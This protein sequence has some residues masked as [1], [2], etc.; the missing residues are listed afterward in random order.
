M[1]Q[2]TINLI[3]EVRG[4]SSAQRDINKLGNSMGT[5]SKKA[6]TMGDEVRNASFGMTHMIARSLTLVT[7]LGAAFTAFDLVKRGIRG[8]FLASEQYRLGVAELTAITL[9]FIKT[10]PGEGL[11]SQYRRANEY[12]SDLFITLEKVAATTLLTGDEANLL[13]S[14]LLRNGIAI[15]AQND[16]QVKGLQALANAIAIV[17]GNSGDMS[18]QIVSET[19]ALLKGISR[20]QDRLVKL[21]EAVDP[22][23]EDHLR[24]WKE[25]GTVLENMVGLLSGFNSVS[26]DISSTWQAVST[27][28]ETTFNLIT[29]TSLSSFYDDVLNLLNELDR[30]IKSHRVEIETK[31]A[32]AYVRLKRSVL[33][34]LDAFIPIFNITREWGKEIFLIGTSYIAGNL[35]KSIAV[36]LVNALRALK[37]AQA[38]TIIGL[39][40]TGVSYFTFDII[41]RK[42][43]F[44]QRVEELRQPF[45]ELL[46]ENVSQEMIEGFIKTYSKELDQLGVIT[47]EKLSAAFREGLI[48]FE[49]VSGT[50]ASGV[51]AGT[52]ALGAGLG[53]GGPET[54]LRKIGEILTFNKE[55]LDEFLNDLYNP[56]IARGAEAGIEFVPGIDEQT[57]SKF[58]S[59]VQSIENSTGTKLDRLEARM[60]NKA[61]KLYEAFL[62]L[63]ASVRKKREDELN[64]LLEQMQD[65]MV[66]GQDKIINTAKTKTQKLIRE[67]L[68]ID[69]GGA[70]GEVLSIQNALEK[71]QEAWQTHLAQLEVDVG[72]HSDIYQR[73]ASTINQLNQIQEEDAEK[74]KQRALEDEDRARRKAELQEAFGGF[75]ALGQEAGQFG[76]ALQAIGANLS[77]VS[78]YDEEITKLQD[79]ID[80]RRA[81]YEAD[82]ITYKEF[83]ERK[84][85]DEDR[86]EKFRTKKR[87]QTAKSTFG[88]L[89]SIAEAYY[90]ASDKQSKTAFRV[91][92]A[93][94]IGETIMNT[95]SAA[96][97]AYNALA[98]IPIVGPAL[99]AAAAAAAIAF[100]IAQVR[101][102][103]SQK[104]GGTGTPTAGGAPSTSTPG[105]PATPSPPEV[106]PEIVRPLSLTVEVHGNIVDHDEFIRELSEYIDEARGDKAVVI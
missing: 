81:L 84:Q 85:A 67:G 62:A 97:G 55:K 35:V 9:S 47:S 17:A 45:R 53:A 34:I 69:V 73:F 91:M 10:Q 38:G 103:A 19:E 7:V 105:V 59:L 26:G 50:G 25:Q 51:A 104:P 92:Q 82:E 106:E 87:I 88:V 3:I 86:I 79:H 11:A 44:E 58:D 46:D 74:R 30:Y 100:G 99:G 54:Q 15:N 95:Y 6:K 61:E 4:G 2:S 18:R 16:E 77:D 43:D 24:N 27:R 39:I 41:V 71:Q 72:V 36:D 83:Q 63:P 66:A 65:T 22:M 80:Q 75:G 37:A 68:A 76:G 64:A 40:A 89:G 102:I 12:A 57:V 33:G 32:A 31:L 78:P 8:A 96:M 70:A 49:D 28:L 90:N 101:A 93:M 14:V 56:P 42:I 52:S 48:T 1:P 5:A 60:A 29:R 20:P 98:P 23:L 94:R 13:A 21:L